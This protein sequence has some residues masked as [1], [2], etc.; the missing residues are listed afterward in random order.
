MET[1]R[2]GADTDDGGKTTQGEEEIGPEMK[3]KR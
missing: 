2:G 3:D 1:N